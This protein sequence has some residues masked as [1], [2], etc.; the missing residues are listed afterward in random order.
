MWKFKAV[1]TRPLH[2]AVCHG[3][4]HNFLFSDFSKTAREKEI[5]N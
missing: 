2:I 3:G 5:P 1:N 4:A